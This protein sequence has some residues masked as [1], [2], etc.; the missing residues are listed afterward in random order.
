MRPHATCELPQIAMGTFIVSFIGNGFV[1]SAQDSPLLSRLSPKARRRLLVLLYFTVGV[2]AFKDLSPQAAALFPALPCGVSICDVFVGAA[3]AGLSSSKRFAVMQ[4]PCMSVSTA[5]EHQRGLLG[6]NM[7]LSD[8][9][10]CVPLEWV[11]FGLAADRL[12]VCPRS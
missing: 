6:R 4:I 11:T 3:R 12:T 1:M 5:V 2:A 8:H 9:M 10:R 7:V